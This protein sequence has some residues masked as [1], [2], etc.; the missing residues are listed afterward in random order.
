MIWLD[1]FFLTAKQIDA[2]LS[3]GYLEIWQPICCYK[4]EMSAIFQIEHF[5]FFSFF[6]T[7]VQKLE[8]TDFKESWTPLFRSKRHLEIRCPKCNVISRW[9]PKADGFWVW[10]WPIVHIY[11]MVPLPSE[12]CL[13][14]GKS[15]LSPREIL[16]LPLILCPCIFHKCRQMCTVMFRPLQHW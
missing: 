11:K 9:S 7:W 3:M 10:I 8:Q 14:Q 5:F 12:A 13:S 15:L 2:D 1:I 16:K 4:T 6:S